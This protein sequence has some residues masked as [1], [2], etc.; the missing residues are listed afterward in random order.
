MADIPQPSKES[1]EVGDVV[2]VYLDSDDVDARY[3]GEVVE[4]ES[5][6]TDDLGSETQRKLDSYSYKV[7][8][9]NSNEVLPVSFRHRDLVP[10]ERPSS[11]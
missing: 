8:S 7:R 1:Y 10:A 11:E 5:V 3:H 4:I 9:T 2:Q 6:L